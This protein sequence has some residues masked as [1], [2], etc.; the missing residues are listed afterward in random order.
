MD[1]GLAPRPTILVEG[2]REEV[3]EEK[4]FE[5]RVL[6]ESRLDVAEEGAANDATT[7]PHQCNAAH[8][9]VP[10]LILFDRAEEHIALRVRDH[11][12]AVESTA[13][14]LDELLLLGDREDL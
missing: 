4:V 12:G 13:N 10:V 3:I 14:V 8:I 2:A 11:L 9:E 6:V 1:D 7:S 5:V